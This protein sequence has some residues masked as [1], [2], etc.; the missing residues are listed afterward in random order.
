[1]K[2]ED[3]VKKEGE[4]C[5]DH[6]QSVYILQQ[7]SEEYMTGARIWMHTYTLSYFLIY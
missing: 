1:M 4:Q 5:V 2:L 3:G 7:L 6:K